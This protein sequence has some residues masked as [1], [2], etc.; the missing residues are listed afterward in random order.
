VQSAQGEGA[1]GLSSIRVLSGLSERRKKR[2]RKSAS[3]ALNRLTFC[4]AGV[5][6]S[7]TGCFVASLLQR[8]REWSEY[9]R[10]RASADNANYLNRNKPCIR[11]SA[12]G[13]RS[14]SALRFTPD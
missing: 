11:V 4:P 6:F 5:T 12:C 2:K 1:L 9:S 13:P 10:V 8:I 3:S 7:N 14:Y